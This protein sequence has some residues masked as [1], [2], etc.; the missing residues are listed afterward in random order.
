[1]SLDAALVEFEQSKIITSN[2]ATKRQNT[3]KKFAN[4]TQEEISNRRRKRKRSSAKSPQKPQR[5]GN[6][7]P[8]KC[9]K[10]KDA[11]CAD[12][13]TCGE[14]TGILG[15][16]DAPTP[17][18]KIDWK[19]LA[20]YFT[21]LVYGRRRIGKSTLVDNILAAIYKRFK[22]AWLFSKTCR[23]N[24]WIWPC[25]HHSRQ[26]EGFNVV[27]LD[28]IVEERIQE[29]NR[30][31]ES[32]MRSKG[33][34]HAKRLT[35]RLK[36][37]L[38][39]KM[40][41]ELGDVLLLF[42]DVVQDAARLRSSSTFKLLFTLGRHIGFTV[43]CLSQNVNHQ[44]SFAHDTRGNADYVINSGMNSF[45]AF[46]TIC[47]NFYACNDLKEGIRFVR[48]STK[49]D[50]CFAF[51]DLT[52]HRRNNVTDYAYCIKGVAS[53]QLPDYHVGK[54]AWKADDAEA[55]QRRQEKLTSNM[56]KLLHPEF[57]RGHINLFTNTDGIDRVLI[58]Q[59]K[60]DTA[61]SN[62]REFTTI[63]GFQLIM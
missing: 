17:I 28:R 31:Q 12:S 33:L 7:K 3:F 51:A 8:E 13:K 26:V 2:I 11:V 43:I 63:K 18:T 49:E 45:D 6:K 61:S 4:V 52:T 29:Y 62:P 35:P 36:A 27:V 5:T 9:K 56:T 60:T 19:T 59:N 30:V 57:S 25:I 48:N 14:T 21:M 37:Q 47:R 44:G 46:E 38:A 50:Y 39:K 10:V 41:E 34:E 54:D 15:E 24:P 32:F 40:E 42:D 23:V 55:K 16:H 1:M 20:P 53:D 22:D 58:E